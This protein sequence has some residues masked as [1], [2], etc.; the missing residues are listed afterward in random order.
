[1]Y[2]NDIAKFDQNIR[3]KLNESTLEKSLPFDELSKL[4]KNNNWKK[5]D[6]ILSRKINE[7]KNKCPDDEMDAFAAINLLKLETFTG[8]QNLTETT[9]TI[10]KT[11]KDK[12]LNLRTEPPVS[13][14]P[15]VTDQSQPSTDSEGKDSKE[16]HFVLWFIVIIETVL[17]FVFSHFLYRLWN[18]CAKLK[19]NIL[20]IQEKIEILLKSN[21]Q[22]KPE[23]TNQT[24]KEIT[25][26][27]KNINTI[28]D[29]VVPRVLECIKLEQKDILNDNPLQQPVSLSEIK[30]LAGKKGKT[31]SRISDNP[32]NCYYRM[33]NRNGDTAN[34]E[35]C[36]NECEAI[37]Q[38]AV[39]SDVCEISGSRQ[40]A[41]SV[42][43]INAGTIILKDD[44][45]EVQTPAKIKFE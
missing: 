24:P 32:D 14:V 31:F 44:V 2:P 36:G 8:F 20:E 23:N 21:S 7:W 41:D 12:Y 11:L 10:Q 25:F 5:T 29:V 35:F 33:F 4:L 16:L 39:L 22:I 34:F 30:Y 38:Y 45:W 43:N 15:I 42:R 13:S 6:S 3:A 27:E 9:E 28:V 40:N 17:L 1:M 26:D 18:R 19:N 37:A